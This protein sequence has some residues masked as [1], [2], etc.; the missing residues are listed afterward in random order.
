MERPSAKLT[1]GPPGI[2]GQMP[3]VVPVAVDERGAKE[4]RVRAVHDQHLRVLEPWE[5]AHAA[6]LD[7]AGQRWASTEA[8]RDKP[9]QRPCRIEQ[10]RFIQDD[11]DIDG[12]TR[13]SGDQRVGE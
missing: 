4:K 5:R 9:A 6:N 10:Q 3:L 1:Q 7:R 2:L 8:I 12:P 13:R 11:T